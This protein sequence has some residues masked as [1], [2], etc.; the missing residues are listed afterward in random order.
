[1]PLSHLTLFITVLTLHVPGERR[2][3]SSP[4]I[5][6]NA[7]AQRGDNSHSHTEVAEPKL[8]PGSRIPGACSCPLEP[9][10]HTLGSPASALLV[11]LLKLLKTKGLGSEGRGFLPFPSAL[12]RVPR[13][14]FC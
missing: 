4:L 3:V 12:G 9:S 1:M 11:V 6:E 7:E 8:A 13:A 10:G 5:D 14:G 2:A